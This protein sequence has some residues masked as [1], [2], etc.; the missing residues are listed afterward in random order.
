MPITAD[1]AGAACVIFG[2]CMGDGV[3]DCFTDAMPFWTTAE[4]RCVLAAAGDCTA[5]RSC[6]GFSAAAD[7]ACSATRSIYCDGDNLVMC[8]D[9]VRSSVSCP[10]AGLVLGVG[11]GATCVQTATGALCGD[12]SCSAPSATCDGAVAKVCN[13][14]KGVLLS[15]DCAPFGQSCINGACTS[16]GGG[17]TCVTGTPA[18]CDGAALVQC[19]GGVE[20]RT[21]CSG[22]VADASCFPSPDGRSEPYCGLGNACYPLKGAETCNGN[23]VTFCAAGVT[24]TI[25]CTTLGF[26]RCIAGHCSS[27]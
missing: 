27:F 3:N 15:V 18:S 21:D 5:V 17:G 20:L 7:A 23:A 24:A 16:S 2:S 19:S 10:D 1:E 8:G 25:D 14:E 22:I 11:T 6:F 12:A 4:A 13:T 26:T 9:G